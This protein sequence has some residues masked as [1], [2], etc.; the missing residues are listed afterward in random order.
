VNKRVVLNVAVDQSGDENYVRWQ[1][2]LS[3]SLKE[4]AGYPPTLF[5]TKQYPPGSPAHSDWAYAF[6]LYAIKEALAQG[7]QTILWMDSGLY[8]IRDFAPLWEAIETSGVYF[9]QDSH[10]VGQFCSQETFAYY[11]IKREDAGNIP[12]VSGAL[13]GFDFTKPLANEIYRKWW[14][15]FDAQLYRGTVSRHSGMEDHR[16]DETI[17][18]MISHKVGLKLHTLADHFCSD[19]NIQSTSLI[20]SGYVNRG[21]AVFE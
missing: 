19:G 8:A 17:L 4:K 9:V 2:R 16:G 1:R 11:G 6:K 21:D 13:I 5:W 7:Y 10:K 12:L 20:R 18:A 3:W 15:A 14:E